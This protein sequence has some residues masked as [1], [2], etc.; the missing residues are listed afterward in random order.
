MPQ[1]PL[2]QFTELLHQWADGDLHARDLLAPKVYE[3]LRR[4]ARAKLR[5][6]RVN[7]SLSGT[8][9]L[10]EA[11]IQIDA[12][13]ARGR[14]FESRDHF[15]STMVRVMTHHLVQHAKRRNAQKRGGLL[16]IDNTLPS[17]PPD[18]SAG[19]R[20]M[21]MMLTLQQW[22]AE[23][24][25]LAAITQAN[26]LWG[27]S[28]EQIAEMWTLSRSTVERRLRAARALLSAQVEPRS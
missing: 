18:I 5:A 22:E 13:L 9:L 24:P 17:E 6:E 11:W 21:E 15:F 20:Q 16:Q 1:D 14:Y 25:Q 12:L 8:E 28:Y 27:L 23:N 26:I 4:I 2:T 7:H 19:S 10:H 3:S